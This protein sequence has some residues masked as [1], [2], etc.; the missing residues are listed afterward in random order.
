[1]RLS[2]NQLTLLH[3]KNIGK[4]NIQ[5]C[6][7]ILKKQNFFYKYQFG[8]RKNHSTCH[9]TSILIENIAEAFENKEHILGIFLDLSKAFDTIDHQILLLK[10]WHCGIR[11]VAHNW[12][13]SYLSNR[14]QLVEINNIWSNTKSI[15]Y[16]VPQGS[17][18]GPLLFSIYVNDLNNCLTLGKCIMYADDTKIFL[19]SNC[20]ETLYEAANKELVNIDKWLLA[21]RLFLN[22]DKTHYVIFRNPKQSF[23]QKN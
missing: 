2:P 19:K 18:L 22:T 4:V 1:M 7:I 12:F 20:Y 14:K 17:I 21:N 13:C 10:L 3:V 15:K 5:S 11:G 23:H 8:F 6:S 9:A 16:G